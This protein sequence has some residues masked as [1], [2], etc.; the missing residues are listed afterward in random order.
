MRADRIDLEFAPTAR[1]GQPLGLALL[2][3]G[4][5]AALVGAF[6]WT[7]A[8]S[9]QVAQ[10]RTLAA[11]ESQMDDAANRAARPA[12]GTPGEMASSRAAL[13]VAR[14]LQTPWADLLTAL[15]SAPHEHV[16]LL[17]IEPSIA[18]QT[19]RL[20]VEGRDPAAM[21]EYLAALQ[22]DVRLSQVVLVSHQV[23][24]QV[25]GQPIRFQVQAAWATTP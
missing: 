13:G 19:V 4:A 23:Q 11:L 7:E 12:P 9:S 5:L 20:V 10:A 15:E 24:T 2:A 8:W 17:G 6:V 18:K 25:I 22:S 16:A 3:A 21:L 1:R 14:G